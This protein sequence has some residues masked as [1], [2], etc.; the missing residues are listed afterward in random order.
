MTQIESRASSRSQLFTVRLWLEEL[1]G[2]QTELRGRVR[3]LTSG[4]VRSFREWATLKRFMLEKLQKP[5]GDEDV[6]T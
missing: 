4:E 3:H 2:S 5:G 6:V 1:G